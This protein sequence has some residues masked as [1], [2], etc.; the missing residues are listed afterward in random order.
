MGLAHS[1]H[2]ILPAGMWLV[3]AIA[4]QGHIP[5]PRDRLPVIRLLLDP[6]I[7][8]EHNG[9]LSQPSIPTS[10]THGLFEPWRSINPLKRES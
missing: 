1:R 6:Q 7:L 8:G 9:S 5:L 3:A 10:D 4:Y 2:F